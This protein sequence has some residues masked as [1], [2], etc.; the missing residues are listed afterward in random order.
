[1]CGACGF[2]M[3]VRFQAASCEGESL[4]SRI[5]RQFLGG[6]SADDDWSAQFV[7]TLLER[8]RVFLGIGLGLASGLEL[9]IPTHRATPLRIDAVMQV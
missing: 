7:E 1:M 4:L 6:E 2:R 8:L 3:A 9:P 5:A